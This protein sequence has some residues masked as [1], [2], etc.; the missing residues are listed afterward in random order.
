MAIKGVGF[1]TLADVAKK[2][3]KVAE[4]L[5]L[6]N[7]MLMDIPYQE[8]NEKTI[9]KESIRSYLPAPVY[10]KANQAVAPQK[11]GIEER[12][13]TAAH[14]ET[15]SVMDA[16]V[17]E[18][19][20]MEKV[21]Q[22]RWNQA[23]GH[24]QA[25]ANEH[26]RLMI[27]GSPSG[28]GDKD[29]GF[30]DVYY[31]LNAA[32]DTSKQVVSGGGAGSDNMSILMV[33][34]GPNSIFGVHPAGTSVGLKRTDRSPG[35]N[36]VQIQGLDENGNAGTYY[37]YDESFEI[38]HGLVVKDYRQAVR[39]CNI[40][41][42]NLIANTSAADIQDLLITARYKLDDAN[43]AVIYMN[44]IAHAILHKQVRNSV[45]AGG[46]LTF[47]NFEGQMLLHF[48]GAPIRVTDALLSTEATVV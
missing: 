36:H 43:G 31:T 5:T 26:A 21:G 25:M 3:D 46:G 8:M 20:G 28:N 10:R 22:N 38:D 9:H 34:W 18:R 1:V 19:G 30:M 24:I 47:Q 41:T 15:R 35:S 48:E 39:I 27:Y 16:K 33:N 29:L 14:F 23:Q 11:T 7:P 4:V 2:G 13:F 42:S 45:S 17:A 32:V 44:R 12:T 6:K 40:D 37:G